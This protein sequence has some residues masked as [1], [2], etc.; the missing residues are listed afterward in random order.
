MGNRIHQAAFSKSGRI[1]VLVNDSGGV[2]KITINDINSIR[3]E[4]IGTS[5]RV[6]WKLHFI[7]KPQLLDMK[8]SDD[9][10]YVRLVWIDRDDK[11]AQVL[12]ILLDPSPIDP[13]Q[14]QMSATSI[15]TG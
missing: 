9:E 6:L 4:K 11:H 5:R 7:E 12:T 13:S 10:T 3:A 1:L 14:M 15:S 8:I 2:F